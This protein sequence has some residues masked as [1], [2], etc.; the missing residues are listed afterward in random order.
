M[1][2]D[3]GKKQGESQD[4]SKGKSQG[5]R[6]KKSERIRPGASRKDFRGKVR[7][8]A[9]RGNADSWRRVWGQSATRR[10]KALQGRKS[11]IGIHL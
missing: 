9:F 7:L 11:I 6:A 2:S 10:R 8:G 1:G 3:T 5:E 4:E